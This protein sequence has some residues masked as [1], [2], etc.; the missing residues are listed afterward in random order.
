DSGGVEDV[1]PIE[2]KTRVHVPRNAVH[3]SADDVGVPD[4]GKKIMR[5]DR[6]SRDRSVERLECAERDE[7]GNPGIA[8]LTEVGRGVAGKRRQEL[9][10]RGGPRQLLDV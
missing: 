9:F 5:V 7:F 3:L 10:M 4:A 8:E 2:Q 1:A 6:R